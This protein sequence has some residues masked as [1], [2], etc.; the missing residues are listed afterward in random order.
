MALDSDPALRVEGL[1]GLGVL[2]PKIPCPASTR[3]DLAVL[4]VSQLSSAEAPVVLAATHALG[5]MDQDA[6]LA[7]PVLLRNLDHASP[8]VRGAAAT[9]LG[10]IANRDPACVGPLA[11]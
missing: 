3:A 2:L 7:I 1:R 10:R 9:S 5:G 6:G 11:Q 8:A 4:V